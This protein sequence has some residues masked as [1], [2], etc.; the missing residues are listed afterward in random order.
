MAACETRG[1]ARKGAL[2][3]VH[4]PIITGLHAGARP[5]FMCRRSAG[6]SRAQRVIA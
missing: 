1:P 4:R 5:P 2:V 6:A 3:E